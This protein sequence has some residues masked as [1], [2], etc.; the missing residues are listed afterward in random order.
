M[1]NF[2]FSFLRILH[3]KRRILEISKDMICFCD[4]FY[5][6]KYKNINH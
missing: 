5:K 4:T 1:K 3:N 6:Y 2:I